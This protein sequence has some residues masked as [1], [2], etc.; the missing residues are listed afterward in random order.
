MTEC[1]LDKMVNKLNHIIDKALDKSC[2]VAKARSIDPNN[3][4]W[5]PQLKDMR[6]KVTKMYDKYKNDRKN[7]ELEKLYRKQQKEYKKH[8]R[9]AKQNYEN[10]QN[11]T[12]AN[13]EAMAKKIKNLTTSIQPKVTTLK[14]TSGKYT[15]IG[16]ETCEEMMAKHFPTHTPK[17]NPEYNHT[18]IATTDIST[19]EFKPWIC[20]LYTSPSP[21]DATLSR[22]P[23][24]A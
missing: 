12:V 8:K 10:I 13:E 16:K 18:K 22:M 15:D 21:R 2:P 23:S 17:T 4:W 3:P 24:S 7:E 20:L 14:L 1:K 5:T 19:P 9:K 11:E 6:H